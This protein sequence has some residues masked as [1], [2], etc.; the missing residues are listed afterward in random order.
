MQMHYERTPDHAE[1]PAQGNPLS[2]EIGQETSQSP[3]T[4]AFRIRHTQA[5]SVAP[6]TQAII[7]NAIAK[8]SDNFTAADEV[9]KLSELTATAISDISKIVAAIQDETGRA[10][11]QM[12][13]WL[14]KSWVST[15]GD[16]TGVMDNM[17]HLLKLSHQMEGT[18]SAA[19]LRSF[20][21]VVKIDH[22][23]HKLEIYKV[24]LGISDRNVDSFASHTDC[25]LGKWYSE[26]EGRNY[27]CRMDGYS[28][29]ASP[30]RA[31]HLHGNEAV[32]AFRAGDPLRGIRFIGQMETDIIEML[33]A[34]ERIA[35]AGWSGSDSSRRPPLNY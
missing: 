3:C 12:E 26:G 22:I 23:L 25:R 5:I 29:V 18:I 24:F 28:A 16:V 30:H 17:K 7:S 14:A 15:S 2:R 1:L 31:F 33:A 4:G 13:G 32:A 8:L 27:F 6:N 35:V 20:I 9:H 11:A 10:K 34:L 21:E 19:E